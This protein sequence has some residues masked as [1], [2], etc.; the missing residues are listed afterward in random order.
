MKYSKL[1]QDP[2]PPELDL[3]TSEIKSPI[4][5]IPHSRSEMDNIPI[6]TDSSLAERT[7]EV[8]YK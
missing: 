5:T 4:N 6:D 1:L 3:E 7:K 2:V 8:C